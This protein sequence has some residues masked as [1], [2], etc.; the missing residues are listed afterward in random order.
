MM[1]VN[2]GVIG[3]GGAWSFHSNA[4]AESALIRFTSVYDINGKQA[5][6]MARRYHVNEMAPYSNLNDFLKADIDAVLVLVP[7]VFHEAIVAKCAAAGKHVLCEKPMATTLE[8]CDKMI[9]V[10]KQA[11]VKLMIAENH[12]FLPVHRYIRDMVQQGVIGDVHLV[13]AYEGVNEIP[14]LSTPDFWKGDPIKAGGGSLMDMGAHKFAALEWILGDRVE[15]VNAVLAKQVVNL[16]EKAEDNALAAVTFAGGAIAD[17]V[18]SFTQVTPPFNSLEL[19][20]SRG[21]ILE[22]HMWEKPL[23]IFSTHESLGESR[24]RWFEPQIEHAGFPKYYSISVRHTDEHFATCII[25]DREPEF[26]PQDAKSAIACVLT[27]YLSARLGRS[28]TKD[29]LLKMADAKGTA[30]LLEDLTQHVRV[31]RKLPEVKRMKSLGFNKKRAGEIMDKHDLDLFIASSPVNVYYLTGL[32]VLHAESN[33]ILFALNN[34]YPSIALMKREG[35]VT[36]LNWGLFRSVDDVCWVPEHRDIFSQKDV[37]REVW[38]KIKK[39]GLAGKRIGVESVAPKYIL[40]CLSSK[41]PDS[42]VVSADE[43]LLDLRLVKNAEE[44]ACVEKATAVTE[45]A[46]QAC[47]DAAQ[48][49]MTDHDFLKIARGVFVEEDMVGWDHLTLSIGDSDPELPGTGRIAKEGDILRFDFGAIYKGYVADVNRHVVLGDVPEEA[50]SLID[51]LILLQEYY[52]QRVKAGVGI[53]ELN[54]EAL[55]YYKSLK[56]SGITF[57]VGHSLGLEC[58]E[59]HLFGSAGYLDRLYEKGMVFEIEAWENFRNTLI[60]VEDCYV[61]TETGCRKITT[62][63]KHIFSK[64]T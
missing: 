27:G 38:S 15:S 54:E 2:F 18:V 42:E 56:S 57:A 58:E 9:D 48:P 8:G 51:R 37:R 36:L 16:P 32:P 25:E 5:Q 22:N 6:K 17:I 19:F 47:I 12:R 55:A 33:P 45:K 28:V 40:D 26:T 34:Q 41:T 13:R 20:G 53:K 39:W 30:G 3:A 63:D 7:H 24:N 52:E 49:G 60:G 31:N 50:K 29:E 4:C 35:D 11:G 14:G 21:T 61:V 23:R 44:I 62:L 59:A 1:P 43:V 46:I 64:P 10:C